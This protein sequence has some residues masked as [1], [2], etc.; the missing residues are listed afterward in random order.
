MTAFYGFYEEIRRKYGNINP[1]KEC[2][3]VFDYLPLGAII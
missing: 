3:E 2:T 1:W